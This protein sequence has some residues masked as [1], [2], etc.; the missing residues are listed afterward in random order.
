MANNKKYPFVDMK[1]GDFVRL[2]YTKQSDLS[3]AQMVCH[4]AGRNKDFKF[5]TKQVNFMLEVLRVS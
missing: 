3:R 4:Q 1:I 2:H 5:K